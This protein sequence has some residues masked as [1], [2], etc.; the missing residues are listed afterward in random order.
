MLWTPPRMQYHYAKEVRSWFRVRGKS[1]PPRADLGSWWH[2]LVRTGMFR[3]PPLPPTEQTACPE[4]AVLGPTCWNRTS[5]QP[6]VLPCPGEPLRHGFHYG[7]E[8]NSLLRSY[9]HPTNREGLPSQTEGT[10][11]YIC[12]SGTFELKSSAKYSPL[13]SSITPSNSS[14]ARS[15]AFLC[16]RYRFH[17][18][19]INLNQN[20]L[21]HYWGYAA[22]SIPLMKCLSSSKWSQSFHLYRLHL[23]YQD[24]PLW[25]I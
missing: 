6:H 10:T 2:C 11:I 17:L 20:K 16:L 8:R 5:V 4:S 24:Q 25:S 12:M 21:Y 22:K 9:P 15:N 7:W 13:S 19:S 3:S 23:A 14:S 18:I 1:L